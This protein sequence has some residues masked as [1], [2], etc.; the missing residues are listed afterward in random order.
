MLLY[1]M[2]WWRPTEKECTRDVSASVGFGF[3]ILHPS[4]LDVD[5]DLSHSYS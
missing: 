1:F 5:V 4:D 3:Y 2:H